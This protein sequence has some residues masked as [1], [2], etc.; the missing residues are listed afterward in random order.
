MLTPAQFH[1]G[2]ADAVL[3]ERQRVLDDAA[4]TTHP[5]R[6]FHGP[7]KVPELPKAVWINPSE[8][9]TT[10]PR[11]RSAFSKLEPCLIADWPAGPVLGLDQRSWEG[12]SG[13]VMRPVSCLAASSHP[14]QPARQAR[15][16]SP[17]SSVQSPQRNIDQAPY[18]IGEGEARA[19]RP[20]TGRA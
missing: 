9:K 18:G 10:R 3:A 8:D 11:K 7:P 15:R 14:G 19:P 2:H 20:I 12:I 1:H 17:R 5:E 16:T 6:F 13:L 4:Y